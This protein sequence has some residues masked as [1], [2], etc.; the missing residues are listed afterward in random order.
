MKHDL[1]YEG[2]VQ[3]AL[4]RMKEEYVPL[5]VPWV[6]W[7]IGV[8]GTLLRPPYSLESGIEFVRG[9]EKSKGVDEAFA[10]LVRTNGRKK[11]TYRYVGHMG[12]HG[13]K[14]PDGFGSTGSVI[15]DRSAQGRGV[16][17][18]AKLLLMYHAFMILGLRKLTSSVKIFNL[19]SAGHLIKCGYKSCGRFRRHH[20]H[21]GAHIDELLFEAF[22]ED[23]EPIWKEYQR[24]SVL[25]K[26][27]NEQRENLIALTSS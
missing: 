19:Q 23:W 22:R 27:T 14:W 1:A 4:G 21:E 5:F 17:T 24:T 20:L 8:E 26:L 9:L 7:R 11:R 10:V 25:P 18:E 6:N 12:I 13:I 3:V 15:G 2:K 16:G